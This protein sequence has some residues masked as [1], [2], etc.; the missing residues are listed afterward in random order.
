MGAETLGEEWGGPDFASLIV[1]E[2]VAEY[3]TDETDV[4]ELGCGGGKFSQRIAPRVKSL[5][6]C[7]ISPQMLAQTAAELAKKGVGDNVRTQLLS[8]VDFTGVANNSADFVFSYDVQLHLQ[9]QNVF[10]Y[11]LDAR[12]VLRDG[13]IFMLHQ[14][15]LDSP[16]GIDHFLTQYYAQTWDFAFDSPD[17]LGHIY[18]MSDG[19]M[20]ALAEA[21]GL[22]VLTIVDDFPGEDSEFYSVTSGRDL[23]GFFRQLPSRLRGGE[24]VVKQAGD[25][26]VYALLASGERAALRTPQQFERAGYEWDA[27]EQIDAAELQAMP[28]LDPEL[29]LWE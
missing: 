17:R 11:M 6:C 25:D 22:E 15:K 12:R 4:V 29:E 23:F 3:L 24:R 28:Q 8:G 9:P 2:L 20:R 27:I 1:D 26:T 13:G 16:G 10:S 7:D 21:A 18:Y 5:V 14:I 19:Q